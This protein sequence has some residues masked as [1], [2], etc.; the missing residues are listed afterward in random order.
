MRRLL[1]LIVPVLVFITTGCRDSQCYTMLEA[2]DSLTEKD[3]TDSA[4]KVIKRV[5][6]TYYINKGK[7]KAYYSL[8]KYQLQFRNQDKNINDSLIDYSISYYNEN[9]DER[10]LALAYYLKARM[11]PNKEAMKYLKKAEFIAENTDDDYLKARI[12]YQIACININNDDYKTALRYNLKAVEYMSNINNNEAFVCFLL[13]LA[14]AYNNLEY[15]DSSLYYVNKCFDYLEN[16]PNKQK[17]AVY[18]NAAATIENT[19]T[20]K[21]REYASKSIEFSPSNNAYQILAKLARKNKDYKLSEKYLNEAL[22]YCKNISWEAFVLYELAQTKE[23]MGQHEQAS[24]LSQRV[25]KLSDSIEDIRAQDSIKE[26]QIAAD[27]D[28]ENLRRLE[29]KDNNSIYIATALTLVVIALCAAYGTKRNTHRKKIQTMEK[30]AEEY[31]KEIET[32]REDSHGKDKK[33]EAANR[34]MKKII[35]R[36]K[37]AIEKIRR[38]DNI[39]HHRGMQIYNRLKAGD[40]NEKWTREDMQCLAAYYRIIAPDFMHGID[41]TNAGMTDNQKTQLIL[42]DIGMKNKDIATELGISENAVRTMASRMRK[43]LNDL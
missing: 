28:H 6:D 16:I 35:E 21:A 42:K 11:S 9:M 18:R 4:C 34:K 38:Q 2:V 31:R 36:Q 30:Q 7:E 26:I 1:F 3:L 43:T 23:L 37:E 22:K 27:R 17:A 14:N 32:I 5:E 24:R 40:R 8:L 12:L 15:S 33:I 41:Y 10:K 19:D 13:G 29:E 39:C 25:V 20:A